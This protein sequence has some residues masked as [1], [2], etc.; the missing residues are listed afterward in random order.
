MEFV[1]WSFGRNWTKRKIQ[2]KNDRKYSEHKC[3][4]AKVDKDRR[5]MRK[6]E[7][8]R[9]NIHSIENFPIMPL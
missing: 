8:E 1:V 7:R 4:V 5:R 3:K 6:R 9:E 2:K